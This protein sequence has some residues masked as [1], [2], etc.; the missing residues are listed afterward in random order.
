MLERTEMS[1]ALQIPEAERLRE[2]LEF[3]QKEGRK[4]VRKENRREIWTKEEWK[5]KGDK[6]QGSLL[7]SP[8]THGLPLPASIKAHLFIRPLPSVPSTGEVWE[9]RCT[10]GPVRGM[11]MVRV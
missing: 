8:R 6:K 10:L 3:T 11:E 5:G 4:G 9:E 1:R 7:A 2:D